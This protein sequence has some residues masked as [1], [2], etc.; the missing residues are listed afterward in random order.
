MGLKVFV[1]HFLQWII[2]GFGFATAIRYEPTATPRGAETLANPSGNPSSGCCQCKFDDTAYLNSACGSMASFMILVQSL[3]MSRC[4]IADPC[5]RAGRSDLPDGQWYDFIIVGA[6]VAGPILARRLSDYPWW[7]VLLIEAGPEEPTMTAFPGLAFNAINS[8]LDWKF[9]TEPT[10]P[11]PTACLERGGICAWPRGKMVSGTG[12]LYGMM[13]VRGHPEIYNKWAREGNVGWSYSEI[14]H[15]FERAEA[16]ANPNMVRSEP[17]ARTRSGGPLQINYFPH[18]PDFSDDLL[19]SAKELRYRIGSLRGF[20]QTGFMVAPMMT[21]AGLRGTTSRYYL[22][23]VSQRPNLDVLI[24]AHVTRILVEKWSARAY[25][26]EYID[27]NGVR[28]VM[29]TNKE[30]ILTAGAIGSP[31]ILMTSGIGPK[32]HLTKL[33]IKS[34]KDLPVGENLHNHVSIGIKM[35]IND[36]HYE[37]L[38]LSAINEFLATRS[39]PLASTG[40]TQVTAFLESS[41]STAGVPDLQIF[42]DGFSSKC[43]RTGL[44]TECP[45]G[46]I[47]TCPE[48]REIVAR[49]T[50]VCPRSKGYMKLRS[51][52]PLDPPLL[53]PNYFVN[54]VDAKILVEGIKKVVELSKTKAL[55]K[56][57]LRLDTKPHPWCARY[58]FGSDAYWSCL[59]RVQTGPENHQAGSCRMGPVGDARAVVD[60]ELRVHGVENIRVADASIFPIVPN[61]NPVAAII[62]VAEKA[63]DLIRAAWM[64]K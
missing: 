14:E 30:V 59:I 58:Y 6:G 45:D 20:N 46:S 37:T 57:D 48:R 4:D 44:Q 26:V 32:E 28:R 1:V 62:M 49:P 50:V 63:S 7:K 21:S 35:S 56:W 5:R 29:K 34:V 38:T 61:A 42:F 10:Q 40:L 17:F 31:Q 11:H 55:R 43:P 41:Y 39:G 23:P 60:P 64:V 54:E 3:M 52:N 12:G 15:Y 47:N 27:K 9:L 33:G 13:Y 53:Y 2:I 51:P 8:S 36:T 24:N 22:R 25:G 19:N 16:P 18:K